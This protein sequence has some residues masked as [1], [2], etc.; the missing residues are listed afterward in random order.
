VSALF[1]AINYFKLNLDMWMNCLVVLF[2]R[3]MDL[4]EW[5]FGWV[6]I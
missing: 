3:I 4:L 6:N 5:I 1:A 2:Q